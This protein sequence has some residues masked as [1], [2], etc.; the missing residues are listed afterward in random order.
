MIRTWSPSS[1]R[2]AWRGAAAAG[3]R[4]SHRSWNKLMHIL[5]G[6]GA[7]SEGEGEFDA[8]FAAYEEENSREFIVMMGGLPVLVPMVVLWAV[9]DGSA[10]VAVPSW[11][12]PADGDD[13]EIPLAASS[14]QI[15]LP[16]RASTEVRFVMLSASLMTNSRPVSPECRPWNP[17]Y[18][19]GWPRSAE[20]VALGAELGDVPPDFETAGSG[21]GS[22]DEGARTPPADAGR[23]PPGQEAA[24]QKNA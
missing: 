3:W 13:Y 14:G 9:D 6:N 21:A 8:A 20:L 2:G 22:Q 12:V 17:R 5:H 1:T 11:C 18:P 19:T 7:A 10:A 16:Q 24:F 23:A 4:R 15:L